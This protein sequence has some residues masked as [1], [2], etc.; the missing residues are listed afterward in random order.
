MLISFYDVVKRF[1]WTLKMSLRCSQKVNTSV[2]LCEENSNPD[3]KYLIYW[4]TACNDK[5][6]RNCC[7]LTNWHKNETNWDSFGKWTAKRR[8]RKNVE[9]RWE[10]CVDG[11]KKC[12][13]CNCFKGPFRLQIISAVHASHST[14]AKRSETIPM[15]Q[16]RNASLYVGNRCDGRLILS[17]ATLRDFLSFSLALCILR[18]F[19]V[20]ASLILGR[21]C[22]F[23]YRCLMLHCVGIKNRT[24]Y[25][26]S[27]SSSSL[28]AIK[29]R[30]IQM[31]EGLICSCPPCII[32]LP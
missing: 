12:A 17:S 8:G 19:K 10:T 32:S 11:S 27:V 29:K 13:P 2:G 6:N 23:H 15:S 22:E 18:G 28:R 5:K 24:K 31:A 26:R 9:M 4:F 30:S 21:T 7:L 16:A 25:R 1:L 3:L 20:C 14:D